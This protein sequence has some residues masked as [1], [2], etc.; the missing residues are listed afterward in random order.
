MPILSPTASGPTIAD[1]AAI[2]CTKLEN[3]TSDLDKAIE[4][5]ANS[6]VEITG[7]SDLRDDFDELEAWGDKDGDTSASCIAISPDDYIVL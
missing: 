5:V 7:D 3:R 2:V 1:Y 6:L 4:W